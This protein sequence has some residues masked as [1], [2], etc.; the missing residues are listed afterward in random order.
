MAAYRKVKRCLKANCKESAIVGSNYCLDHQVRDNNP[1]GFNAF[2][3]N[4]EPKSEIVSQ[5]EA[6]MAKPELNQ[7][8]IISALGNKLY[9]LRRETYPLQREFNQ[10]KDYYDRKHFGWN[11][12][13]Q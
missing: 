2:K 10:Y 1:E 9:Q 13:E 6:F 5:M 7:K 12:E 3:A 11:W 4:P 8:Q